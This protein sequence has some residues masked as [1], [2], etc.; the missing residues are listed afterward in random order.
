MNREE[1]RLDKIE[2][3]ALTLIGITGIAAGFIVAF[4]GLLFDWGKISSIFALVIAS[5]LYVFVVIS[6]ML[7][8]FLAIKVVNIGDYRWT[9]PSA[10][11]IFGL[12]D[13]SLSYVKR[14]RVISLFYSFAHNIR[15]VNRK[16][17]FLGGAQ[18]WFRNSII[19]LLSITLF[20]ATYIPFASYRNSSSGTT[21][22]LPPT[23]TP[24]LTI[25]DVLACQGG[26]P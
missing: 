2:S 6:L 3:K 14:E 24:T 12:T 7:T 1:N 5:A 18:L 16:A 19:L 4:A 8:I 26:Q 25:T 20:S 22:I 15:V 11:D 13:A 21:T 23:N 10:N 9:Y 17:T